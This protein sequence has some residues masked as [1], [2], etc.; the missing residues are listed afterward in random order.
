MSRR[1]LIVLAAIA[2]LCLGGVASANEAAK[3]QADAAKTARLTVSGC[4]GGSARSAAC[5]DANKDDARAC[6]CTQSGGDA[7][8]AA[9]TLDAAGGQASKWA[10]TGK[11]APV[12]SPAPATSPAPGAR[13]VSSGTIKLVCPKGTDKLCDGNN[14]GCWT[15]NE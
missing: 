8:A 2:A 10:P 13:K 7:P 6:A 4:P 14:C 1:P 12:Q 15:R 11:L 9:G 5:L 3:P